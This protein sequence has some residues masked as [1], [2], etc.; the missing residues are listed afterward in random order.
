M[1]ARKILIRAVPV[2]IGLPVV[3]VLLAFG[4]FYSVL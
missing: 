3:L 4:V 2:V 1:N